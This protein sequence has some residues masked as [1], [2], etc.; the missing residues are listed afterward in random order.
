MHKND[1]KMALGNL[2]GSF[3]RLDISQ[4]CHKEYITY[5]VKAFLSNLDLCHFPKQ[6]LSIQRELSN[7]LQQTYEKLRFAIFLIYFLS[8]KQATI[9][10]S[11]IS[12]FLPF[13]WLSEINFLF[14]PI[15]RNATLQSFYVL[16]R[17]NEFQWKFNRTVAA[18]MDPGVF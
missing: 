11:H 7:Y 18:K 12:S 4:V 17:S 6:K 9:F 1:C 2:P 8:G 16:D 10:S 14:S 3:E 13:D 5:W 15:L